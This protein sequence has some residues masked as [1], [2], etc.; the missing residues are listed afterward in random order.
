MGSESGRHAS[1]VCMDFG[2][3]ASRLTELTQFDAI[4]NTQYRFMSMLA[5]LR[6]N[7]YDV[8]NVSTSD[9]TISEYPCQTGQFHIISDESYLKVFV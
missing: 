8:G 3:G 9:A 5:Y 6:S 7:K 4:R 1:M 2:Y